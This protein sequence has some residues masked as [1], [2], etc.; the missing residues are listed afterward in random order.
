MPEMT[1]PTGF[2]RNRLE[3]HREKILKMRESGYAYR[4]IVD[5]LKSEGIDVALSTVQRFVD[6]EQAGGKKVGE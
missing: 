2:R 4:Q 6:K 3:P 5:W 1:K